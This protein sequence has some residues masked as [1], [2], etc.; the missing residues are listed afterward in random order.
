MKK[1]ILPTDFSDN[2]QNTINY[3]LFLFRREE[4]TFYLL[5]A[6]NNTPSAPS[7]KMKAKEKLEQIIK[8]LKSKNNPN[9]QFEGVLET[10]S[11]INLINKT[12]IDI[13]VDFVFMGTKG[14]SAIRE[15][16]LGGNTM[17]VLKHLVACP[18][19]AV[20]K[21]YTYDLP[22]EIILAT[23]FK[24]KF[25]KYEIAPLITLRNLWN[26]KLNILHIRLEK[27]LEEYQKHNKKLL[28]ELLKPIKSRF[29]EITME[30]TI[31]STLRNFERKNP[32]IGMVALIK[33]KHG[34]LQ[35]MLREPVIRNMT[36]QTEVPLLVLPQI[37]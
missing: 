28:E 31:A 19:V 33:T 26:S 37:Q 2:A 4:C 16:F 17:D 18:V 34:F 24:H 7:T 1:I 8:R 32:K 14:S 30:D 23:D 25:E 13:G 21:G 9:H 11:V 35:R 20:P 3:T 22:K 29:I 15:I 5:H 36:F 10:N 6:Y 12:I 27:L